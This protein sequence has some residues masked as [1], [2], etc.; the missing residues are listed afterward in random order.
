MET[1][2]PTSALASYMKRHHT[3]ATAGCRL[4][5]HLAQQG[6]STSSLR[7]LDT[8]IRSDR[9]ALEALMDALGIERGPVHRSATLVANAVGA[10]RMSS[11]WRGPSPLRSL[12]ELEALAIG[13][14]GKKR[15]WMSLKLLAGHPARRRLRRTSPTRRQTTRR[16][17]E[18]SPGRRGEGIQRDARTRGAEPHNLIVT[19][20]VAPVPAHWLPPWQ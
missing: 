2:R 11:T 15:L 5:A 6:G 18:R 8:E 9:Y 14:E 3:C 20:T 4:A 10:L 16:S 1:A 17:G 12:L 13:I 19:T 7:G